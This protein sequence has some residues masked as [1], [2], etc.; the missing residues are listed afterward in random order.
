MPMR[1]N[2]ELMRQYLLGDLDEVQQ[3]KIEERLLTDEELQAELSDMQDEL[4]DAYAFGLL[5]DRARKL[6]EN[7]FL[8]SPGRLNKL[9]VSKALAKYCEANS[10]E[11][12]SIQTF[13][14]DK[15]WRRP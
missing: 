14:P 1:G 5:S 3:D 9:H 11:S 10:A 7:N 13:A 12:P 8:L 2:A 15:P 6:F 4:I